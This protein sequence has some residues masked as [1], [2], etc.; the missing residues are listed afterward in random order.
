MIAVTLFALCCHHARSL[1]LDCI[2]TMSLS[3][4]DVFW[5]PCREEEGAFATSRDSRRVQQSPDRAP[6]LNRAYLRPA[7]Q[8]CADGN[9]A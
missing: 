9:A 1:V 8:R 7:A 5:L 6:L 3:F 4:L 2:D